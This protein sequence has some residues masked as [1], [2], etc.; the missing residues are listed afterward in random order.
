MSQRKPGDPLAVFNV[1]TPIIFGMGAPRA[2]RPE[3][4]ID[5]S[6][7]LVP[8]SR[9]WTE[10]YQ[11]LGRTRLSKSQI[12]LAVA[13]TDGGAHVDSAVPDY[14]AALSTPPLFLGI[15]GIRPSMAYDIT[16]QAGCE[17][18][19]SLERHFPFVSRV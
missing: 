8:L 10:D 12:V 18:L 7:Q 17:L 15:E 16:A 19:E 4:A 6:Y 14:H 13:D 5:D 3:F 9:W 2:V 11:V 1:R